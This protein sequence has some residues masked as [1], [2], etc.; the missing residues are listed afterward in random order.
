MKNNENETDI[1]NRSD[2][3]DITRPA[4]TC[5]K[6]LTK[7]PNNKVNNKGNRTTPMKKMPTE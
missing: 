7:T 3:E 4:F 5:P 2:R 6:S 1:E